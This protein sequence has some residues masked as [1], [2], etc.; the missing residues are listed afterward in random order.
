MHCVY[1]VITFQGLILCV[2]ISHSSP[3][4]P[5]LENDPYME[6]VYAPVAGCF[7]DHLEPHSYSTDVQ[8][9]AKKVCIMWYLNTSKIAVKL[10]SLYMNCLKSS[11]VCIIL[12]MQHAC[13][14]PYYRYSFLISTSKHMLTPPTH[15]VHMYIRIYHDSWALWKPIFNPLLLFY[16]LHACTF[17]SC[18]YH[19]AQ[20]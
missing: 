5:S 15:N 19:Y 14:V 20:Y 2:Y 6:K 7:L 17:C 1:A 13:N 16:M 10:L 11:A 8:A 12:A 9:L 3:P 4:P 18:S